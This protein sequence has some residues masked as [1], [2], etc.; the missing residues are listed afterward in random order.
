MMK[1]PMPHM[2][3]GGMIQSPQQQAAEKQDN[4]PIRVSGGEVVLSADEV[5]VLGLEK[6]NKIRQK[7]RETMAQM[8]QQGQVKGGAYA[9]GGYVV[10]HRTAFGY[11]PLVYAR[12]LE[13][14]QKAAPSDIRV[15]AQPAAVKPTISLVDQLFG[16]QAPA[17][18]T[19]Q[20]NTGA[21]TE[22]GG[23][24]GVGGGGGQLGVGQEGQ[25]VSADISQTTTNN[26]ADLTKG[27]IGGLMSL[28]QELTDLAI[29]RD[30]TNYGM[31]EDVATT[32]L[33]GDPSQ[34][35]GGVSG[36]GTGNPAGNVGD[37]ASETGA[38]S[39]GGPGAPGPGP[40]D[41]GGSS[42]GADVDGGD[43][44]GGSDAAYARGGFVSPRVV[45]RQKAAKAAKS[46]AKGFVAPRM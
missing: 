31:A 33:P 26:P 6:I 40:G 3:E 44:G 21:V 42:Q 1:R 32:D 4:V 29:D 17:T 16:S 23:G 41:V 12:M 22:Q 35:S 20:L 46:K 10:P 38:P 7:A 25:A 9:D 14:I 34:G 45:A 28:G 15:I 5:R 30:I 11:D 27:L 39:T 36:I 13:R 8:H 2:A 19:G 18:N 37:T 24:P 43:P